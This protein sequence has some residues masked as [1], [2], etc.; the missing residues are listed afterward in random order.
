MK[1]TMRNIGFILAFTALSLFFAEDGRAQVYDFER[2]SHAI[3]DMMT[4]TTGFIADNFEVINTHNAIVGEELPEGEPSS[5]KGIT[6]EGA[7][8]LMGREFTRMTG[9]SIK[10]VSKGKGEFGPRNT[11]NRPDKWEVKQ[12]EKFSEVKY[13]KGVGY[14]E[15]VLPGGAEL[16]KMVY[17][18][19]Y[20]LYIE[21]CC[22][23]CHGDPATSPT[24]DSKDL[25]G[26][27]MEN[28]KLGELRGAIS[29][30]FP[31]D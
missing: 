24:G 31:I 8:T 20:P 2:M 23:K 3:V 13:P 28:Y 22:L 12:L 15:I 5:Y 10:F 17:R 6:P 29:V 30:A 26:F 9:I 16:S 4:S 11:Y 1:D 18:Y 19:I 21:D 25:T 27:E 14:G 7:A